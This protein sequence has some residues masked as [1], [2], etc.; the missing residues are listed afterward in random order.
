M[1]QQQLFA[2]K[3]DRFIFWLYGSS[4]SMPQLFQGWLLGYLFLHN[5]SIT[6][7]FIL[8]T[9]KYSFMPSVFLLQEVDECL[10]HLNRQFSKQPFKV[11]TTNNIWI[12]ISYD[13]SRLISSPFITLHLLNLSHIFFHLSLLSISII[14]HIYFLRTSSIMLGMY[15]HIKERKCNIYVESLYVGFEYFEY[16]DAHSSFTYLMN[17]MTRFI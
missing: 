7:L 6:V 17:I 1:L 16:T 8:S 13:C 10:L 4:A 14:C 15:T 2:I 11:K 5:D 9:Q 3:I 12:L